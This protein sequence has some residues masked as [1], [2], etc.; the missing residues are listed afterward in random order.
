MLNNVVWG[1]LD[2]IRRKK[3]GIRVGVCGMGWGVSDMYVVY[4][5][6]ICTGGGKG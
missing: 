6:S 5:I 4:T 1:K 2:V 3:R